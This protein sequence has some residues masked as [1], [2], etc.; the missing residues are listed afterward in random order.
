MP[1]YAIPASGTESI[2]VTDPKS[3]ENSPVRARTVCVSFQNG[4][5]PV[6]TVYS[7]N[8]TWYVVST[9]GR[10]NVSVSLP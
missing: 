5:P 4:E 6:G 8:V 1:R 10:L 7:R 2:G 3:V 9:T